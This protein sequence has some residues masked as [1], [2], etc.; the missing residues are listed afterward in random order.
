MPYSSLPA[1]LS[2]NIVSIYGGGNDIGY[3]SG[4]STLSNNFYFGEI[5]QVSIY[6]S[7]TVGDS[8]LFGEDAIRSKVLYGGFPYT[9]IDETKIILIELSL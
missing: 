3:V 7:Y 9:L 8:V 5:N 6:S 4:L 1:T 2:T